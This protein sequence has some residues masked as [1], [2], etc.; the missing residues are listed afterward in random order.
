MAGKLEGAFPEISIQGGD[1]SAEGGIQIQVWDGEVSLKDFWGERM[2][3]KRRRLGFEVNMRDLNMELV[4]QSFSFG[5]MGGVL[6]G[7]VKNLAFSFGQPESF[8]L[9]IRSVPRRGIKQYVDA[10]AVANLSI[11]SSGVQAPLLPWFKYYP[12]SKLGISCKL[13]NDVFTLRG[14]IVEGET[15]Y[16][17]KRGFLRG[18]NVINRNPDNRIPW[19]DMVQRIGRIVTP[20]GD[21][22][23]V[24][25][26]S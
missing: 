25:T 19:K 21:K 24:E 11:L 7:E 26:G 20:E 22:I 6:E 14:T 2:L 5:Q 4:T 18:I 13:E 10:K 9:Q 12:Y 3:S 15:E 23:R 8:D 17:V 16:L 1:L